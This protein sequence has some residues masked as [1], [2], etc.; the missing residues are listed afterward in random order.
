MAFSVWEGGLV[1]IGRGDGEMDG[2]WGIGMKINRGE[3][4]RRIWTGRERKI[5]SRRE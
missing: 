5:G 2:G 1:M 4:E 3:E